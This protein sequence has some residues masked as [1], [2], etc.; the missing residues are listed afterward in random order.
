MADQVTFLCAT[1]EL[2]IYVYI[3]IHTEDM[4]WLDEEFLDAEDFHVFQNKSNVKFD[5]NN[6]KIN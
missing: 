1:E 3:C 5:W 2:H 6:F 4:Q